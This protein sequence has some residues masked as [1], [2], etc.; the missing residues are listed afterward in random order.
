MPDWC[1]NPFSV[2]SAHH[3]GIGEGAKWGPPGGCGADLGDYGP[4]GPEGS[5]GRL[6]KVTRF[7]CGATK[8]GRKWVYYASDDDPKVMITVGP[9]PGQ[10][11]AA[12]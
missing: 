9:A 7:R 5:K 2:D 1:D 11:Q 6:A 10:Q 12:L 4:P 3:Q 8:Q